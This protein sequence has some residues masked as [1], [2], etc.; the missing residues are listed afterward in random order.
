MD[1]SERIEAARFFGPNDK[2]GEVAPRSYRDIQKDL[3][4]AEKNISTAMTKSHTAWSAQDVPS[5]SGLSDL[6]KRRRMYETLQYQNLHEGRTF[7]EA[8]DL[9]DMADMAAAG[10]DEQN[11]K[12][13]EAAD[14]KFGLHI[15][16][17]AGQFDVSQRWA[18][19]KVEA[20]VA[21]R[22]EMDKMD[23]DRDSYD[24]KKMKTIKKNLVEMGALSKNAKIGDTREFRMSLLQSSIARKE[25]MQKAGVY[26]EFFSNVVQD[27]INS[28]RWVTDSSRLR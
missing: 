21:V 9:A 15:E 8:G 25:E 17:M 11:A 3:N 1:Y 23:F 13:R 14:K 24:Q 28:D 18:R 26:P 5:M 7:E 12:L 4:E 20:D 22:K 10:F 19:Q 6:E 2:D 16:S 27:R